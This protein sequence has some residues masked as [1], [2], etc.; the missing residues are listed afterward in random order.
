MGEKKKP[1]SKKEDLVIQELPG[2][3]L[4][5]NLSTDRAF[6]LNETSAF[7]W[8]QADG[9]KTVGE[10]KSL[11]ESEFNAAVDE[12][13]IWLALDQLG[14]DQLLDSL[15]EEKFVGISRREVVRR[16]G[17]SSLVALP[18]IASLATTVK[19]AVCPGSGAVTPGVCQDNNPACEDRACTTGG[20]CQGGVCAS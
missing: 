7:V 8:K 6:C 12:D 15:P 14:R 9:R 1:L 4:I 2:E 16:I 19:A 3:L 5:Y 18:V 20:T 11:M 13:L 17:L 10:I